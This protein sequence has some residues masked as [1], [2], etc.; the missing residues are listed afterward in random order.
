MDAGLP[1]FIGQ[2]LEAGLLKDE[3]FSLTLIS[4]EHGILSLGGTIQEQVE[5]VE[6]RIEGYLGKPG[7]ATMIPSE[8]TQQS[9]DVSAGIIPG[10]QVA[11]P[12]P[13]LGE[14]PGGAATEGKSLLEKAMAQPDPNMHDNAKREIGPE[15]KAQSLEKRQFPDNTAEKV[16]TFEDLNPFNRAGR[17][18]TKGQHLPSWKDGWKWSP[19]EGAAGWWQILLRG[20]W[21][22]Q[23]KVM[24]NQPCIIDVSF[25][26][27]LPS[28]AFLTHMIQDN[29]IYAKNPSLILTKHR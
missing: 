21:T 4:S 5:I 19:V 3:V 25:V 12:A 20:I 28:L 1:T 26:F 23:V 10:A 13:G 2:L 15:T 29:T 18:K 24:K 14:R 8:R 11:P 22:D 16:P 17:I 27:L 9:Q 6:S 7:Q